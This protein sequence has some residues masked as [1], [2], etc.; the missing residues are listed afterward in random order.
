MRFA[1]DVTACWRPQRAG[2]LT[3][4]LELT[5]AI[6]DHKKKDEEITLLCSRGR[7]E[8]LETL[9]A[10]AMLSDYRHEVPLKLRWIPTVEAQIDADA[11]LYP[12]WPSPPF[13]RAGAPPAA[14][15]VHD[16]AFRLTPREVPWQQRL[17]FGALLPR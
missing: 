14:V 5:K 6:A 11:I 2:M 7:P 13:R 9:D 16:L 10:E 17:Y 15:F 3:V 1:I 4:S 12:Y 8:A